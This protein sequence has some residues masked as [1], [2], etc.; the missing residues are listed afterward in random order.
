MNEQ[1]RDERSIESTLRSALDRAEP[2]RLRAALLDAVFP[3]GARVRPHL[4]LAVARAAS[5]A[6]PSPLAEAAAA[7]V[8]LIHCASLVHDDLPCFD[9]ADTRRGRPSVHRQ[10]GE[11]LALLAGDALIVTAFE[12]LARAGA[13]AEAI[14]TLAQATGAQGGLVSGQALEL[15]ETIRLDRY[16]R[17][18]T[19][20]LFE[21][22]ARLGAMGA[23][24][25]HEPFAAVGR[26]LGR[27][28]QLADDAADLFGDERVLG[29]P[30]GQDLA[31]RR[32]SAFAGTTSRYAA[33]QRLREQASEVVAAVPPCAG[34][35]ALRAFVAAV[36]EKL[37]ARSVPVSAPA[38]SSSGTGGKLAMRAALRG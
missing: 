8:E 10:Y 1:E 7:A 36:V 9:D 29:K 5:G 19:A 3:G 20:G 31:H 16:H 28:Y 11:A 26:S 12:T 4:C 18:K 24:A 30:T 22:A 35:E 2:P 13:P 38:S 32:P 15:S 27:F 34:S 37:I 21:A 17:A 14:V 25:P 6:A 23:G 33:A